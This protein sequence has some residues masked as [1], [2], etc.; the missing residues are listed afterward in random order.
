MKKLHWIQT[1][2]D[3]T[4]T[5]I[6]SLSFQ[7]YNTADETDIEANKGELYQINFMQPVIMFN[8]SYKLRNCICEGPNSTE[9]VT[10]QFQPRALF[11][12]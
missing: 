10:F 2:L 3:L 1:S 9:D 12:L 4:R 6:K 11:W 7:S 8:F 5:W